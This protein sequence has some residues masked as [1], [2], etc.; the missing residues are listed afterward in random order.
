MQ[1][2]F[3]ILPK[4]ADINR[5]DGLH[6]TQIIN[7]IM[8]TSG[9]MI[10]SGPFVPNM[11]TESGF[12]L[13]DLIAMVLK[14]RLPCRIGEAELDGITMSPDGFDFEKWELYEYK[15]T[16]TSMN[17]VP[18]D[19]WRWM[20][21]IKA[22]LKRMESL[23]CNLLVLYINGDYKGKGP[24]FI[25]YVIEFTPLEIEENWKLIVNHAKNK[26]WLK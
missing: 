4:Q 2:A 13:E 15:C 20:A 1:D 14:E 9:M 22:Y 17:R 23:V 3:D 7:D 19:N 8:V 5:T 24:Q 10:A 18:V 11:Y 21:Q 25:R 12:I 16:W 26:G 6:V